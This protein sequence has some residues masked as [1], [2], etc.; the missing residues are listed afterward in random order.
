MTNASGSTNA[1]IPLPSFPPDEVPTVDPI[2]I[3]LEDMQGSLHRTMLR[4][5]DFR[6]QFSIAPWSD[7]EVRGI[8][9]RGDI[10]SSPEGNRIVFVEW[11]EEIGEGKV[12]VENPKRSEL[13]LDLAEYLPIVDPEDYTPET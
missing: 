13:I 11:G 1:R 12:H 5:L 7:G 8:R 3:I 4:D 9:I 2:P 6:G 10:Q